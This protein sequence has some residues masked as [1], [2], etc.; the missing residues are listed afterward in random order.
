MDN[1]EGLWI[2]Q[3]DVCG[4]DVVVDSLDY[5]IITCEKRECI[6]KMQRSLGGGI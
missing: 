6:D 3:C 2:E 4:D 1:S 5:T